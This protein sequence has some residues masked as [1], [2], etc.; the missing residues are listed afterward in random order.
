[1]CEADGVVGCHVN[2]ERLAAGGAL[3][4]PLEMESS[5]SGGEE[6]TQNF[7]LAQISHDNDSESGVRAGTV[8]HSR[9]PL[10]SFR[11]TVRNPHLARS[12]R[13]GFFPHI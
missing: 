10:T 5:G 2:M 13:L 12:H 11:L 8:C 1:M 7:N 4:A 3:I 9:L 6:M